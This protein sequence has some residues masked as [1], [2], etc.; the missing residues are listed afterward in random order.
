APG[1]GK[2]RP[3]PAATGRAPARPILA[4]WHP[5]APPLAFDFRP[6]RLHPARPAARALPV[7]ALPAAR[8]QPAGTDRVRAGRGAD[9]R[10]T[11]RR[12]RHGR[13]PGLCARGDPAAGVV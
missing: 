6:A 12:A 13:L 9:R 7:L 10:T 5:R 4:S 11:R 8:G 2:T 1:P 3:R